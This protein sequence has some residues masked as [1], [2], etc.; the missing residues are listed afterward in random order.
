MFAIK[1]HAP[2][3]F[4]ASAFA[5]ATGA[6]LAQQAHTQTG[7]AAFGDWRSDAPGVRRKI[8][9]ADLPAP[10]AGR[11]NSAPSRVANI[12]KNAAPSAPAGFSVEQIASG[13]DEPR[14]LRV[15]PNG[16][17]FIAETGA[18]RIRVL[19]ASGGEPEIF[20][21]GLPGVFGLAFYPPGPSPKYLYV[22]AS[23]KLVRFEYR[24]GAAR[25]SAAPKNIIEGIPGRGHSTRDIAFSQDGKTLYLSV[26][27]ASNVGEQLRPLDPEAM[28]KNGAVNGF[29]AAWG[30]ETGRAAVIAFDPEGGSRRAF[31]NGIRNCAGLAMAPS[32]VLWCAVNERDMLGDD[33][34]PDYATSVREGGFY[35]WPWRYIGDSEDP[36]HKGERPDLAGKVTIPD[37]LFQAHSAPLGIAFSDGAGLPQGYGES[38]FVTLHGSWNRGKRTG[39][40]VVRLIFRDGKP[41]GEYEDFLTGFVIDDNAVWGRPVGVAIAKDGSVLVSEDGNGTVWRVRAV[42]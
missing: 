9:P 17:I 31:A 36:R 16:D 20:A 34:P 24:D 29:A 18:G 27:S 39:Y 25:A 21:S 1:R 10:Y 8:T 28:K 35:G 38:A 12:P 11:T 14:V 3:L 33:L 4:L 6:T 32:G 15:A 42:R 23:T 40:K 26:G 5:L 2:L 7:A 13:L 41:T 37:V 19:R 30:S 22:A